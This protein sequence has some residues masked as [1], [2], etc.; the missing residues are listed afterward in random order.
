MNAIFLVMTSFELQGRAPASTPLAIGVQIIT[1]PASKF[2]A[3]ASD[4]PM[5]FELS[6]CITCAPLF[7][8]EKR[9]LLEE[10]PQAFLTSVAEPGSFFKKLLIW[11]ACQS[12]DGIVVFFSLFK[13]VWFSRSG[14]F[15]PNI[16][17]SCDPW[18][19]RK[20]TQKIMYF[21]FSTSDQ[22]RIWATGRS[23]FFNYPIRKAEISHK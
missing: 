6:Y 4:G 10:R 22:F 20:E 3:L 19:F 18:I 14:H 13:T 9:R 2:Y 21:L 11:L 8:F 5:I 1:I 17:Y 23:E 15:R 7:R 12:W 16:G